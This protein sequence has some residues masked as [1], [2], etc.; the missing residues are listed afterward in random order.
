LSIRTID[1]AAPG[2]A[3]SFGINDGQ[4]DARSLA[5]RGTSP[6]WVAVIGRF[7]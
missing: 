6:V 7:N 4:N 3:A 2:A 5:C 1:A